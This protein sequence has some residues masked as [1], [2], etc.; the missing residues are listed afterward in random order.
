MKRASTFAVAASVLASSLYLATAAAP[1]LSQKAGKAPEKSQKKG[2]TKPGEVTLTD[3]RV[4]KLSPAVHPLLIALE[5]AS[6]L[7]DNAD[8][9]AKLAA[10]RAAATTP[11]ERYLI[12]LYEVRHAL[13]ANQPDREMAAR[14]AVLATGITNAEENYALNER[15]GILANQRGDNA[16]AEQ[17]FTRL[18]ELKPND[19]TALWNLSV[20]KSK[21]KKDAEALAL[22]ERAIAAHAAAGTKAEEGWYGRA[23][24]LAQRTRATD[25][26]IALSRDLLAAYPSAQNWR[27]ALIVHRNGVR[28]DRAA[29]I[30]ALRLMRASKALKEPSEYYALSASLAEAGYPGEAKAVL[31]EAVSARALA[32]GDEDYR[33]ID[34]LIAGKIDEDRRSLAGLEARASSLSGT[35]ALKGGDAL[36]GYGEYAKAATLY[37]AALA[38]GGVDAG[39]VNTHLGM[40]LALSGDKAGAEAAF[41]AVTGSRAVLAGYWLIWLTQPQLTGAV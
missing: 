8:F 20:A 36:L 29:N 10:A 5:T 30:D 12:E 38:K 16:K 19:S 27:N 23:L 25:K 24:E 11:E 9:D 40:A 18:V 33:R 32:R 21:L 3:G 1:A 4:V 2:K 37:R 39:L 14:E 6:K 7:P 41:R 34:A 26:S 22:I 35:Q 15:I 13:A 31:D 17:A 28:T